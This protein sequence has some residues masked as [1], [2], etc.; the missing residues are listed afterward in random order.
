MEILWKLLP[1]LGW[2]LGIG[3]LFMGGLWYYYRRNH[4]T[5]APRRR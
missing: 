3:L 5:Q 2:G 1:A 4:A